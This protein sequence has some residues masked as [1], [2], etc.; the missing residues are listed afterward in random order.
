[1]DVVLIRVTEDGRMQE[2]P[3]KRDRVVIGRQTDCDVRVPAAGI[4]RRHCEIVQEEGGP[5]IRDLGS[6]NGT[7]VNQERVESARLSAGDLVSFGS[8]VFVVR[9]DGSP[10]EIEPEHC[11]EDGLPEAE[12]AKAPSRV[13]KSGG[14]GGAGAGGAGGVN[15]D[16]SVFDFDF[17]LSDD[18]D[19]QPPL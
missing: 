9:I 18:D 10:A 1:M 13:A 4:S 2:L 15:D 7:W 19:S 6:S 11:F 16:S 3:I 8:F 5:L 14:P 17:D 12:E